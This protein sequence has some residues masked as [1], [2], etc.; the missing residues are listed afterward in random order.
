MQRV[1]GGGLEFRNE[2]QIER[3]GRRALG[4]DEQPAATHFGANLRGAAD[5]IRQQG[6]TEAPSFMVK[7]NPKPGQQ[8]NGLGIVTGALPQPRQGLR[9]CEA[10]HAPGIERHHIAATRFGH[11]EHPAGA[12]TGIGLAGVLSQPDDL[13]LGSAFETIE[14]IG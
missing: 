2:M 10:G 3:P 8:G 14:A 1:G 12:S 4:M 11:H 6:G 9:R 7:V 5:H 13:L